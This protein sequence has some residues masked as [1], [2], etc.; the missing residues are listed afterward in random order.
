MPADGVVSPVDASLQK[1]ES[2]L[3]RVGVNHGIA[4]AGVLSLA[5]LDGL[6]PAEVSLTAWV[7]A[8]WKACASKKGIAA[9]QLQRELDINYKS[10]LF[11][12]PI[13]FAMKDWPGEGSGAKMGAG[14]GTVE[15]D[16]TY[17]GG[18]PCYKGTRKRGRGTKKTPV[19]AMVERGG[20]LRMQVVERITAKDFGRIVD[21]NLNVTAR[22]IT[23]DLGVYGPIG[24]NQATGL[25]DR[26]RPHRVHPLAVSTAP[27]KMPVALRPYPAMPPP[28]S[29]STIL[30][31][32]TVANLNSELRWLLSASGFSAF[33]LLF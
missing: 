32:D 31:F 17:V 18:K 4:L 5:V 10:A 23:D 14:S 12:N 33:V 8:S 2:R 28:G 9:L 1:A 7:Y 3:D 21:E 6:M 13:R 22:L 20:R 16:E 30:R 29:V 15:A 27:P 25:H 26:C 19:F 24:R 11:L